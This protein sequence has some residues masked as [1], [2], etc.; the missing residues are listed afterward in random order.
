V[1]R[2]AAPGCNRRA[3]AAGELDLKALL[4]APPEF[5]PQIALVD[6]PDIE[7]VLAMW[8]GIPVE[9]L[10]Q[11]EAAALA[12]LPDA[13]RAAVV[14]QDAAVS[15]VARAVKRARV[16][17]RSHSRPQA[18]ML[19]AGP[20]GVGKT[21][22]A[23]S[24]ADHIFCSEVCPRTHACSHTHRPLPAQCAHLPCLRPLGLHAR[25]HVCMASCLLALCMRPC[26]VPVMH[27]AQDVFAH[28]TSVVWTDCAS[29]HGVSSFCLVVPSRKAQR[30]LLAM[31][32][33]C[34][35]LCAATSW[36]PQSMRVA[37]ELAAG[38]F[39]RNWGRA[40]VPRGAEEV[41]E[42]RRRSCAST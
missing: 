11:G 13:L 7:A 35:G 29:C 18:A 5:A 16:G 3:G 9:R 4:V 36:R 22:L 1:P 20:S 10:S 41:S 15:A 25:L 39:A 40:A 38:A 6:T 28:N 23:V 21:S 33:P 31:L 14:G 37:W 26:T 27:A 2:S 42:C 32:A 24:L 12:A 19:F 17:L 34:C 8:T 30:L